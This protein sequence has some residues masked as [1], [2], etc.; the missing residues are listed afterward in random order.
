MLTQ[1]LDLEQL[2]T[3][4]VSDQEVCQSL[5][6]IPPHFADNLSFPNW[7]P[8][9]INAEF[10]HKASEAAYIGDL[11]WYD[12]TNHCLRSA[13]QF[14]DAGNAVATQAAFAL[15]F[16]GVF[17]S[18]QLST[19]STARGARALIDFIWEY[20]CASSTF[21]VGD[22]VAPTY[23][24]GVLSD[25]QVSK[26]TDPSLAIGRVVKEYTSATTGVK[27]RLTSSVFMGVIHKGS[28][29]TEP[30]SITGSATPFPITGQA[31]QTATSGGGAM[32]LRGGV[33]GSTSGTGGAVTYGGGNATAGNASGGAT[34][35]VAG[36]GN[37]TGTG[38]ATS[39]TSGPSGGASGTAGNLSIDTGSAAGG[40]AGTITI[41]GTNSG[42]LTLGRTGVATTLG[43]TVSCADGTVVS[44]TT[45]NGT[46]MAGNTTQKLGFWGSTPVV[47]P[48]STGNNNTATVA[49]ST[50]A[51]YTNTTFT[52]GT[53]STAYSIA[54]IIKNLK[55][56]GILAS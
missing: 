8:S 28:A 5:R 26:V 35:I 25:Q 39:I 43:D 3:D 52:G 36:T 10:N 37:G 16:A 44:T 32:T 50:N 1:H 30:S 21:A 24:A 45:G 48:A 22:Y 46:K 47:Q 19:D 6:E 20:P 34:S 27:V 49:G 14:T 40:T 55:T 4:E 38:G 9:Q 42:G 51:V 31:P 15:L 13:S 2:L 17:M 18:K 56:A 11:S 41:G 33:G 54:D 12:S 53:G 29:L 7:P 23:T